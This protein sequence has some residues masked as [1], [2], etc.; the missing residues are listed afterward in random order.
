MSPQLEA[1]QKPSNAK[2][3]KIPKE[4]FLS[5]KEST[6]FFLSRK[7]LNPFD[8]RSKE[9]REVVVLSPI[10]ANIRRLEI[11]ITDRVAIFKDYATPPFWSIQAMIKKSDDVHLRV[12]F[13]GEKRPR[14]I[15]VKN[16]RLYNRSRMDD[17]SNVA[18]FN[19]YAAEITELTDLIKEQPLHLG[20]R[21][22][23]FILFRRARKIWRSMRAFQKVHFNGD[24]AVFR[25]VMM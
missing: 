7:S 15:P 6:D 24:N 11:C 16:V 14:L 4:A 3:F 17:K 18:E 5:K 25:K 1:H 20:H 8:Y 21:L 23:H 9:F 22:R 13:P 12:L 2:D 10:K 19:S